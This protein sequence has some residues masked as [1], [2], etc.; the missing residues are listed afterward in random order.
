[1]ASKRKS[2]AAASKL[3]GISTSQVKSHGRVKKGKMAARSKLH[4]SIKS[5]TATAKRKTSSN[6]KSNTKPKDE[7]SKT[8]ESITT[9]EHKPKPGLRTVKAASNPKSAARRSTRIA[10]TPKMPKV[11]PEKRVLQPRAPLAKAIKPLTLGRTESG[12]A[13]EAWQICFHEL[14]NFDPPSQMAKRKAGEYL[15]RLKKIMHELD[16]MAHEFEAEK[17]RTVLQ[18]GGQVS[19]AVHMLTTLHGCQHKR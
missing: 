10:A 2:S 7:V 5:E 14:Q 6:A 12:G 19:R 18:A 11:E 16:R 3:A 15:M 17:D 13:D 8:T 4:S 9:A 1:M